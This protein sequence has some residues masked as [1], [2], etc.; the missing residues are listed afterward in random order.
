MHEN[1]GRVTG[2]LGAENTEQGDI[3]SNGDSCVAN[4]DIKPQLSAVQDCN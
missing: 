1:L 3:E 4:N 2:A